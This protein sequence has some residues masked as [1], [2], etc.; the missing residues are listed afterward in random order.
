MAQ[1]ELT[2]KDLESLIT[3]Q[4]KAILNADGMGKVVALIEEK[5]A[6]AISPLRAE[7]T[8]WQ[9]KIFGAMVSKTE[10]VKRESGLAFGRIVRA[11]AIAKKD[12]GGREAVAK[13]LASWGDTDIAEAQ[14]KALSASTA[15]D[16]GYLVAE[17]FS[18]DILAHRKAATVV[19]RAG[20]REIPMPTGTL[21]L[22][23]V[24]TG[25]T[26]SYLGENANITNSQ[27]VFGENILTW[28]KLAVL[29]P[30]S[31]DLLRYNAPASDAVV[32]D[33]IVRSLAVTEDAA[34]LRSNGTGGNPKG[35]RYWAAAGNITP[36]GTV[37]VANV[38]SDLGKNLYLLMNNNV[39]ITKGAWFFS[40]RTWYYLYTVRDAIGN[41]AFKPEMEQGRLYGFPFYV[42]TSIPI[43]LT[44]GANSDCSEV[45]FVNMDDM[46]IGDSQR[47]LVDV[48]DTAAYHNGSSVVAAFS[49]DQTVIRAIAEHDFVARDPNAI[50]VLTGVRWGV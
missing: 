7:A 30:I 26:G 22:P 29:T 46:A 50:A 12:G 15:S 37:S 33:D 39:P 23:K 11:V 34:L 41:F 43:T 27:P 28:K 4:V 36:A 48:S 49:L 10:A 6:A 5:I 20:P 31:N 32:R 14:T 42:S 2:R 38:T 18:T 1:Q 35:L 24:A 47:L 9:A 16:G 13:I 44:V 8:D 21:H 19:R 17:Q 25:V 45:Y 3:D 40:P